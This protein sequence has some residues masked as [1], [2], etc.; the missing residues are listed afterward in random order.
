[1]R[2]MF[3][4]CEMGGVWATL[5]TASSEEPPHQLLLLFTWPTTCTWLSEPEVTRI[6][7]EPVLTCKVTSPFTLRVRSKDCSAAKAAGI[8]IDKATRTP[9]ASFRDRLNRVC[10]FGHS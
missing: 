6:F 3:P 2:M 7:P 5:L 4:A 9:A 8:Y 10:I 1:M